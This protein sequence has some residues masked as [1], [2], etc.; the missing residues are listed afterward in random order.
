MTMKTIDICLSNKSLTLDGTFLLDIRESAM[1]LGK[2]FR[3]TLKP[4]YK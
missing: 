2:P 1:P 4:P 3:A